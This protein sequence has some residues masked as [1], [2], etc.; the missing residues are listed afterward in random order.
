MNI[1]I[2][3]N[4]NKLAGARIILL[5]PAVLIKE[6]FFK[7]LLV[8]YLPINTL[9]FVY[10]TITFGGIMLYMA[11]AMNFYFAE[12]PPVDK[13][14]QIIDR[15]QLAAGKYGRCGQPYADVNYDNQDKQLIFGCN[16]DLDGAK[17]IDLQVE[18]GAFGFDV[19]K[20]QK[21]VY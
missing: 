6:F 5:M 7:S 16:I 4:E 8:F 20:G 13:Q 1:Y 9:R 14:V 3:R 18:E 19:I 2:S 17:R 12:K 15:G 21:P 10:C 11:M